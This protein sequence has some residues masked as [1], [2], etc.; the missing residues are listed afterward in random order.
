M[1]PAFTQFQWIPS[2]DHQAL[3]S[4][5]STSSLNHTSTAAAVNAPAELLLLVPVLGVAAAGKGTASSKFN[6]SCLR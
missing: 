3:A 6:V 4:T 5:N 2:N 1:E